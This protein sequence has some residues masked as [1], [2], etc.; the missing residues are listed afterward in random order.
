[1][2]LL[3]N[4]NVRKCLE[5][6]LGGVRMSSV[7]DENIKS[8]VDEEKSVFGGLCRIFDNHHINQC[9]PFEKQPQLSAVLLRRKFK[10]CGLL[11]NG[12]T[13]SYKH[14]FHNLINTLQGFIMNEKF[15]RSLHL[16]VHP[17]G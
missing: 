15:H 12:I 13:E 3:E 6:G 10:C 5:I 14:V 8:F 9:Q 4:I 16:K 11:A 7:D 17:K 1:M 2:A